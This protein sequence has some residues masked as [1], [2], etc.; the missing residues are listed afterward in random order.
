MTGGLPPITRDT[1]L[2]YQKLFSKPSAAC[3]SASAEDFTGK[4]AERNQA[5]YQKYPEDI[6]RVKDII[7]KIMNDIPTL[8][9][10]GVMSVLRFRQLGLFF[11]FHGW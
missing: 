2:I 11:G 1:D 4:V 7:R 6:R 5:Y 3:R 9:S 10:G 8:P